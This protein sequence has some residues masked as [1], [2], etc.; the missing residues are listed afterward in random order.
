LSASA[1][2]KRTW[3]GRGATGSST[4]SSFTD[5]GEVVARV[6]AHLEAG[7]DHVCLQP[8]SQKGGIDAGALEVLAPLVA[9]CEPGPDQLETYSERRPMSRVLITGS[10]DGLGL[11]AARL[12][13][14]QHHDVVLHA[15]TEP[16]PLMRSRH[17]PR[18]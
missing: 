4:P 1:M 7:A 9:A 14:H 12:L 16:G 17:C 10:S 2:T 18:R 5:A 11:G 13:A 8:L 6:R 15:R 3:P